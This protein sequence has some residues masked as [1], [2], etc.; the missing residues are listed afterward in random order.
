[1]LIYNSIF[2]QSS[3][4]YVCLTEGYAPRR[5]VNPLIPI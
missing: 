5:K 3:A 2:L 1:M 4:I